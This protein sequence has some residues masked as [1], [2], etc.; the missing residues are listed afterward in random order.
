MFGY[1]EDELLKLYY[2]YPQHHTV[3]V[4]EIMRFVII[5][6]YPL[7]NDRERIQMDHLKQTY[8][9]LLKELIKGHKNIEKTAQMCVNTI[10]QAVTLYD[11]SFDRLA[12]HYFDE[13]YN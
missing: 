1:T 9:R 10:Y 2:E 8:D 12:N 7:L 13:V 6:A 4:K 11:S 3:L 5:S